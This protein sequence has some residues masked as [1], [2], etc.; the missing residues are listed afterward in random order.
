MPEGLIFGLEK[1]KKQIMVE[2]RTK[3]CK[4][5]IHL[6][7][8]RESAL[9]S[10]VK[11]GDHVEEKN[12]NRGDSVTLDPRLTEVK[13]DDQIQW[14][15]RYTKVTLIAE[16]NKPADSFTVYDDVLDGRF[17]DRLKLDNQ[18]GSLTITNFTIKHAGEYQLRINS[19]YE[20][21]R[22]FLTVIVSVTEG[23]SVT[24]ES[25]L[26]EEDDDRIQWWFG[27]EV[28]LI[29]EI[30][31]RADSFTVY[32]D[33]LDGRF[34]DRLKLDK[35]TRSLTITNITIK[36]T[37]RYQLWINY[38][39]PSYFLSVYANR[40]QKSVNRGDSVTLDSRRSEVKDGDRLQWWFGFIK[41]TVI[42]EIN[43]TA[44]SFTV[45]DDVLDGRFRDRLK[46][47]NQTGS[48][49]ITN[50]TIKH[51]GDYELQI[52]NYKR[53]Y[54]FLTVIVSMTEGDSVA[55]ESGLTE[56][57]DG[58][59]ILWRFRYTKGPLIA[60]INKP[61]DSFTV[62]DD[63]LD[64]RFRDRLK[65]DNQTGSLTIT[66]ITIKHAGRYQLLINNYWPSSYIRLSVYAR[67]PVPVI[68]SNSS[69]CSSSSS[70]SS[71]CSL[72]CSS[73][74]NVSHV[75]LSWYK[76]NSLLS[77][78]SVSDLSISLSLPLEVEYQDK[79]TYSCVLNNPIS[80]QTQHLD[81]TQLCH[82]CSGSVHCCGPT[83]AV[84]RLVLAALVGVATVMI[85]VYDIRSRRAERDQAHIHTSGT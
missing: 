49:T 46:L 73:A 20:R 26:T 68:S 74:V 41:V 1:D 57:E 12:V 83:E 80:H 36:H 3:V 9:S 67:L 69:Q 34:R 30:N 2:T 17:R 23:D 8:M 77:N 40:K 63:V 38:Y 21:S 51:T 44:D 59:R 19:N 81:I 82:T 84:I 64:G 11:G 13:D 60:E 54:F 62:Y 58:H 61:A 71:Y 48:L 43:V 65:L 5:D 37:G 50:I 10:H 45:Y 75:T 7:T 78:I 29:A 52:N 56:E 55:L 53:V 15:F 35:Q 24:L 76:G 28:T 6:F 4:K 22:F 25:G 32:D 16:I 14:R 18:T 79:N 33:V 72:V 31:K 47:D 66:N 85:V 70:S 42:A 39:W 27:D